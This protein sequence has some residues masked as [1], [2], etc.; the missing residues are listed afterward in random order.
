M[1]LKRVLTIALVAVLLVRVLP[2]VAPFV[3]PSMRTS[4]GRLKF[5]ADLGTAFVMIALVI[6]M[7][8]RN[9]PAYAALVAL[10]SVPAIVGAWRAIRERRS[11]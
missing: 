6:S 4:L 1:P 5:R 7:L 8:V 3:W 2:I 11:A 9:E 10:L